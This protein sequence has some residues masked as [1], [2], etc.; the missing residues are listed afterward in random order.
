MP[1]NALITQGNRYTH[2]VLSSAGKKSS[3]QHHHGDGYCVSD[4]GGGV[5][6]RIGIGNGIGMSQKMSWCWLAKSYSRGG[7]SDESYGVNDVFWD[8]FRS[9]ALIQ[10]SGVKLS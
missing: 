6:W 8:V 3:E 9:L 10:M 7:V 5:S 4:S 2:L 1:R